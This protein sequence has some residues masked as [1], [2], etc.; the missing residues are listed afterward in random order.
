MKHV[1]MP[2]KG[3]KESLRTIG[4]KGKELE[5]EMDSIL[6]G[7]VEVKATEPMIVRKKE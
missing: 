7:N 1:T 4:L 5:S 6:F 3:L 2:K